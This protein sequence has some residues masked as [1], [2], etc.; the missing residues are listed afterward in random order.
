MK[1]KKKKKCK[2]NSHTFTNLP[3]TKSR[4]SIIPNGIF[5]YLWQ[6]VLTH[7]K[8]IRLAHSGSL[9]AQGRRLRFHPKN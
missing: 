2:P 3:E 6:S 5:F 9:P 1:K 4:H 7:Y 8:S